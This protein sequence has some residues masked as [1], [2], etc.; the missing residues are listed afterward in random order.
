MTKNNLELVKSFW[1][2]EACGSHFV[3]DAADEKEFYTK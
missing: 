1:E 3:Q 2:T